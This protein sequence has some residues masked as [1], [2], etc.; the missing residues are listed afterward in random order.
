MVCPIFGV[1]FTLTENASDLFCSV[2]SD[3]RIETDE[4]QYDNDDSQDQQ[5]NVPLGDRRDLDAQRVVVGEEEVGPEVDV[6]KLSVEIG[7]RSEDRIDIER[8]ESGQSNDDQ[9]LKPVLPLPPDLPGHCDHD[10]QCD[11]H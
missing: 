11:Q 7:R 3:Q 2:S 4:C 1:Q 10:A 8:N 5:I 6:L 9:T